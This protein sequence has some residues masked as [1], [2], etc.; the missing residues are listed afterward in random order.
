M[1]APFDYSWNSVVVRVNVV[2]VSYGRSK[3]L[4]LRV[5]CE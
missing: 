1:L 5:C 3:E 2:S 4:C